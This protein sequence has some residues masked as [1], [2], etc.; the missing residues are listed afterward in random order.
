VREINQA[1]V[2]GDTG[3]LHVISAP[4]S[5]RLTSDLSVPSGQSGIRIA[6]SDVTLDLNGFTISSQSAIG[7]ALHGVTAP[8]LT[9]VEIRNGTIRDFPTSGVHLPNGLLHRVID[10][11][12]I[13]NGN[14]GVN[15]IGTGPSFGG[16]LVR[17]CTALANGTGMRVE[18]QGSLVVDSVAR[19]NTF[20]GFEFGAS[21][22]YARNAASG[23]P[24]SDVSGGVAIDC[25]LIG[26]AS[27]CP[28]P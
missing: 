3:A 26:A 21:T 20:M 16:H 2:S 5:Y 1:S 8:A 11:R 12:V 13:G 6:A 7:L 27:V 10:V 14:F 4:G 17:G 23:N 19:N 15:I 9:N 24:T 25:N 18:P 22:G 28:A